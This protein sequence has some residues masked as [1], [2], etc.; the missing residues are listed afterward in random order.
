MKEARGRSELEEGGPRT[1]QDG[2]KSERPAPKTLLRCDLPNFTPEDSKWLP[3]FTAGLG[4]GG[5]IA[6]LRSP[7]LPTGRKAKRI[8]VYVEST[9]LNEKVFD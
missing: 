9:G 6:V 8:F 3:L 1:A 4:G 2:R 7:V 5:G